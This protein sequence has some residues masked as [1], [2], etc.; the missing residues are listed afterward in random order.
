VLDD[1]VVAHYGEPMREQRRLRSGDAVVLLGDRTAI[2]VG[3]P[4]RL[5]WLDSFTSQATTRLAPGESSELLILDPQGHVEHAAGIVDD[6]ASAWLIVDAA[7]ADALVSWLKRMVFRARVTIEPRA[8]RAGAGIGARLLHRLV[9][10]TGDARAAA[11]ERDVRETA[12]T[13]PRRRA[14]ARALETPRRY[15]ADQRAAVTVEAHCTT[16]SAEPE[17]SVRLCVMRRRDSSISWR[18]RSME[19][20]ACSRRAGRYAGAWASETS[21]LSARSSP[22]SPPGWSIS[23]SPRRKN[24]AS[25]AM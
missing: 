25:S 6:G 16:R 20:L 7:D 10:G 8:E 2:E 21:S 24:A 18:A 15:R 11:E 14:P 19:S 1:G 13:G 17:R 5:S 4:E 9:Q 22:S 23:P 3:G 12:R